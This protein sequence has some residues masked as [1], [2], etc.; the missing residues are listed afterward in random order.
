MAGP[1]PDPTSTVPGMA[2][3]GWMLPPELEW[4]GA[5]AA[6]MESV[7]EVGCLR[8]RSAFALL[9]ACPGPVYCID[10]WNDDAGNAYPAFMHACGHFPNLVAIPAASPGAAAGVPDVDMTFIDGAHAYGSVLADIAAW[11]PKTRKLICG[12]DYQQ[13]HGGFPGVAEAVHAVF[14][15]ER[16]VVPDD[17]AIWTVDLSADQSV[18][19][20]APRGPIDCT[21]EYGRTEAFLI[22]WPS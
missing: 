3:W 13:T 6:E 21:D 8:G 19:S 9:T 16:V 1:E 10:P 14:G 11:L 15:E 22:E 5:R 4:L 12:H 7:V 18:R 2:I 17:T 20:D